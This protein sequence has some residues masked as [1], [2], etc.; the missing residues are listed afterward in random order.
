[1]IFLSQQEKSKQNGEIV[2]DFGEYNEEL[3]KKEI[4]PIPA[5]WQVSTGLGT[6]DANG[7]FV[8]RRKTAMP[9]INFHIFCL[10]LLGKP[11]K[12]KKSISIFDV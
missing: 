9:K 7:R 12:S 5:F 3:T 11:K 4:H 10:S 8:A 2:E 6:I 1:M